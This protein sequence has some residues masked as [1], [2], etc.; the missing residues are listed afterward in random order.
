MNILY[1]VFKDFSL[2]G[3]FLFLV[4]AFVLYG[5]N[6]GSSS[7]PSALPAQLS[8]RIIDPKMGAGAAAESLTQ[9]TIT[10][11]ASDITTIEKVLT[12]APWRTIIHVA[13]GSNRLIAVTAISNLSQTYTGSQT[14]SLAAGE[15]RVVNITLT[16]NQPPSVSSVSLTSST[17]EVNASTTA[18]CNATDP[19]GDNLTYSWTV[20]TGG[21]TFS[22]S[23]S[24][25]TYTASNTVGTYK[26]TCTVNDGRSGIGQGSTNISQIAVT[27]NNPPIISSINVL[28]S[29]IAA[30]SGTT[31]M[32][33]NAT[34]ADGDTLSYTW[35][36]TA[37]SLSSTTANPTTLT[38]PAASGTVTVTCVV[39]DSMGGTDSQT[40]NITISASGAATFA[41]AWW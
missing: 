11:S 9:V 26:I 5:C 16:L 22:G 33:C 31:T 23:G 32:T 20:A 8:M 40:T 28:D 14:V 27:G 4:G 2:S 19:D 30:A 21:G 37:G 24:T 10:V 25:V 17:I 13:A 29:N 1:R 34:D 15:T 38:A 35:S 6:S 39:D 12:A 3:A 18:T 41:P 7:G 36:A